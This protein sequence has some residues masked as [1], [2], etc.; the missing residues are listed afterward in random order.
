MRLITKSGCAVP[1]IDHPDSTPLDPRLYVDPDGMAR[2]QQAIFAR[3]WQLAGHVADVAEPGRFVTAQVGGES[4][5][6]VRG[7]DRELRAFR[8]VC[9][10]RA[11]R[12]REGRGDCGKAIR[13]PY[14]GWTYRTDGRLIGVPEGRGFPALDKDALALMPARVETFA[15]L[16]FVNLDVDAQPLAEQL[17]GLADKLAP[18]GIERLTRFAGSTSSQPANWKIVADNYLEGYHVP[19]AHPGL[20]RLLDYQRYDVELGAGY[21]WFEAPLRAKPSG[22]RLERTYQRMVRPM[23]GLGK[24][25]TRVWRYAYIYPNTTIDLYP[26]QVTTWQINPRGIA[27][28]HDVWACY[29][30]RRPTAA[31]RAVQRLNHRLNSEVAAEDAE[32]VARVQAGMATTGWRPG[33]LGE[34]EAAVAWFADRVRRD[35]EAPA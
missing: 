28:T 27:A 30:A 34:R 19:I 6:V 8:N 10:H 35:L 15:G 4:A 32:L 2:E 7:E 11:A 5:L 22:N 12:L 23:P 26:D 21:A 13:C 17:H 33:P 24:A 3:T 20:M 18:Y 9:R 1:A 31:M 25:D 14:H 16:V 29:R